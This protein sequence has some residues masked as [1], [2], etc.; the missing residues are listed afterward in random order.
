MKAKRIKFSQFLPRAISAFLVFWLSSVLVLACCGFHIFTVSATNIEE[1]MSCPMDG[2]HDCCKKE[3][4]KQKVSES[5]KSK[6][7]CCVFKPTKTLAADLQNTKISKQT[8]IEAEKPQNTSP[9][10]FI[11]KVYQPTNFYHSAVHNRGSTY[12]QNC[13]FRI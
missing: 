2:G 3:N 8:V 9:L 11:K 10:L 1:E 6:E 5:E 12:L 7:D 4:D 13:I